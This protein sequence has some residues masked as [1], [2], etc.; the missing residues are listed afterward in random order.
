MRAFV[1]RNGIYLRLHA[2]KLL[3]DGKW[4][5]V[6]RCSHKVRSV[7]GESYMV[8]AH[9]EVSGQQVKGARW[10]CQLSGIPFFEAVRYGSGGEQGCV[11]REWPDG[12]AEC[13]SAGCD[14]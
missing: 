7:S 6:S 10:F 5:C 2:V 9:N 12:P 1:S 4:D 8:R 3:A 11:L 14:L 13:Q